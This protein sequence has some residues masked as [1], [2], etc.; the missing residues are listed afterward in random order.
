MVCGL[1]FLCCMSLTVKKPCRIG[2]RALMA[3]SRAGGR[4]RASCGRWL[5][6][7]ARARPAGT[8]YSEIGIT[9]ITPIL[10]LFR[11]LLPCAR[12]GPATWDDVLPRLLI[13]G[14][15]RCVICAGGVSFPGVVCSCGRAAVL[16]RAAG[17][18]HGKGQCHGIDGVRAG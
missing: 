12:D 3:G 15:I 8:S 9:G 6:G 4:R 16:V 13:V 5:P 2:A 14:I 18:P 10:G 7:A 11:Y 1:A 17:S